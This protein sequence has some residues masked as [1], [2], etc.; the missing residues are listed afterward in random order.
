[1]K[2]GEREPRRLLILGTSVVIRRHVGAVARPG[3]GQAGT[4]SREPHA[5]LIWSLI[6]G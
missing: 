4:L 1:M 5:V 6:R 2:T 3:T